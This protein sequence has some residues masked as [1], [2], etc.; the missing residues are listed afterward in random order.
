M[1]IRA[2]IKAFTDTRINT[3]SSKGEHVAASGPCVSPTPQPIAGMH[4]VTQG[5]LGP[6]AANPGP[7]SFPSA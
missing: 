4:A 2:H 7:S 3:A 6:R 5:R 1:K